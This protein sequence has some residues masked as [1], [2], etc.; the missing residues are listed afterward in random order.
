MWQNSKT[1]NVKKL[2]K[3]LKWD[4][5]QKLKI[6]QNSK[7]K[8]AKTQN[9]TNLKK[10]K[11]DKFKNSKYYSP[12]TVKK[13]LK[14]TTWQNWNVTKLK[15][16]KCDII[17][18]LEIWPNSTTKKVTKLKLKKFKKKNLINLECDK[19]PKLKLSKNSNCYKTQKI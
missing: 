7:P 13:N 12:L 15:N 9:V 17:Q 4:K 11:F 1:Q 16:S 3:K 5:I 19:T 2:N 18:K 6:G 14:L 8:C 10:F